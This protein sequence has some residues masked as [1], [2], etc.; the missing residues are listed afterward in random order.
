MREAEKQEA[1]LAK[2]AAYLLGGGWGASA[3]ETSA[4]RCLCRVVQL[5]EGDPESVRVAVMS[6]ARDKLRVV[7]EGYEAHV[8]KLDTA[9]ALW[10]EGMREV[11]EGLDL[12]ATAQRLMGQEKH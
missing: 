8:R 10:D 6:Q 7:K 12:L 1:L 11:Q 3:A 2:G 5:Q 4:G 9:S